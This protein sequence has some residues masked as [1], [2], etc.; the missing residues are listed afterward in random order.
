MFNILEKVRVLTKDNAYDSKQVQ[1]LIENNSS[2]ELLSQKISIKIIFSKLF[3]IYIRRFMMFLYFFEEKYEKYQKSIS[4][5][6][7]VFP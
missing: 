6:L 5:Y 7:F 1:Q 4:E 2:K 3:K